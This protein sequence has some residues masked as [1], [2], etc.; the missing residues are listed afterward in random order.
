M[1]D[2]TLSAPPVTPRGLTPR[3]VAAYLRI[4]PDRVRAMIARG[5]LGAVDVTPRRRGR[6]R[7]IVLPHHLAEWERARQVAP[8]PKTP[9][10]RRG[11]GRIDYFPDY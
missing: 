1:S 7:Y 8:P 2:A 5:E 10:R 3:E 9:P 4:G 6:P 11:S